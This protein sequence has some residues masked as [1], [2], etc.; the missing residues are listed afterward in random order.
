MDH[1][2]LL[3]EADRPRY[4]PAE[5]CALTGATAVDLQNWANRG[6]IKPVADK[7]GKGG[8]RRYSKLQVVAIKGVKWLAP[9]GVEPSFA[10]LASLGALSGVL[11][12][13]RQATKLQNLTRT[14]LLVRILGS[15]AFITPGRDRDP[16]VAIHQYP[17]L[18]D[19][20]EITVAHALSLD[21]S[22]TMPIGILIGEV[23]RDE[24]KHSRREQPAGKASSPGKRRKLS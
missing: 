14:T 19:A 24:S 10:M 4:S 18:F 11:S 16:K 12:E 3:D 2:W 5:V 9:V 17:A 15:V 13:I 8:V 6:I 21:P 7:P 1:R 23:M 20:T 22:L